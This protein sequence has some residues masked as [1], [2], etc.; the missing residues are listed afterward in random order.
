M[1]DTTKMSLEEAQAVIAAHRDEELRQKIARSQQYV[2]RFYRYRNSSSLDRER[3]WLYVAVTGVDEG[4]TPSGWQ[5]QVIPNP[6]V[7]QIAT[8]TPVYVWGG[9]YEEITPLAFWNAARKLAS[10][11]EAI[12]VRRKNPAEALH[13]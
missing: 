6:D 1:A 7:I 10:S 2:G 12:L 4:G 11:V 9:G 13:G 8:E 3:W 5:F